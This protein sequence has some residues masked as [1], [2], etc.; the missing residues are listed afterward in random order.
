LLNLTVTLYLHVNVVKHYHN[1]EHLHC[2]SSHYES[3]RCGHNEVGV[4]AVVP[5]GTKVSLGT[6]WRLAWLPLYLLVLR[7]RWGHN[8]GWRDCLVPDGT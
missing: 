2:T 6:Q 1:K 5:V 8:E 7:C 3:C 4:N